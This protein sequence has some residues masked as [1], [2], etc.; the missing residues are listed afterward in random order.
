MAVT[1][2]I[3]TQEPA[4]TRVRDDFTIPRRYFMSN[5]KTVGS[6]ILSVF[7]FAALCAGIGISGCGG[8]GGNTPNVE[9]QTV[10]AAPSPV[11]PAAPDT[12]PPTA[13][14]GLTAAAISSSR[15]NLSWTAAT[16]NTAVMEYRVER[17]QGMGCTSFVEI[18]TALGAATT[19]SDTAGLVANTTYSYRVRAADAVPLLGPYSNIAQATTPTT[20]TQPPTAPTNL[21]ATAVSSSQ[22]NLGWAAATDNV[23]VTQYLIERCLGLCTNFSQIGTASGS[24]TTF[25]D[26]TA[27][28]ATSY[29]Y[30]VRA[31]DAAANFGPYSNVAS[32][33]TQASS[34]VITLSLV[35]SRTSGVGPLAVTFDATGTTDANV[36][37]L[38]FHEIQYSWD[39]G[40]SVCVASEGIVPGT[41]DY[42]SRAGVS[43]RNSATGPVASHIFECAGTFNVTLTAFDGTNS[44]VTTSFITVTSADLAYPNTA[45]TCYAQNTTGTFAGCP[46]GATQ[47]VQSNCITI[48]SAATANT[49]T[50]FRRGDV[51]TSCTPTFNAVGGHGL[52]GSFGS[53]AKPIL[54]GGRAILTIS[55]CTTPTMS[56]W[57]FM[58][59]DLDGVNGGVGSQGIVFNGGA[60]NITLLRLTV[61]NSADVG[62]L[63]IDPYIS[64]CLI[65]NPGN[66][67]WQNMAIVDSIVTNS[68]NYALLLD[69]KTFTLQ[70]NSVSIAGVTHGS[71]TIRCGLSQKSIWS[72]NDVSNAAAGIW[73]N[74]APDFVNATRA[75]PSGTYSEQNVYSDNKIYG[76][77][78]T[79]V[80]VFDFRPTNATRDERLRNNIFERNWVLTAVNGASAGMQINAQY[81]T[82]RNNLFDVT[83][84]GGGTAMGIGVTG[85]EPGPTGIKVYNNSVYSNST[86]GFSIA[87]INA[88]VLTAPPGITAYNNIG[89]API[90]L[91]AAIFNNGCGDGCLT[92]SNNT[93]N[94]VSQNPNFVSVA[95]NNWKPQAG[96]YA[97]G[98]GAPMLVPVWSDFFGVPISPPR[99]LG[100]VSH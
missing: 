77:S 34:N 96:S 25:N 47:S 86:G 68:G 95:T 57:R 71:H 31:T 42:G 72:N 24:A 65:A 52:V 10:L 38:P 7:F 55:D 16:D 98:A 29:N 67:I 58:D 40:D 36:T 50:L 53:G 74:R 83:L 63:A 80:V 4:G 2:F 20:D 84:G 73:T 54:R 12:T 9:L 61:R 69:V 93:M 92:Q 27:L 37:S 87:N 28:G 43:S 56:D 85:I 17:C 90:S 81:I 99:D 62:I 39:F 41:W 64:Q 14:S 88:G 91:G 97:I 59:L 26:V 46:S 45:T 76:R 11:P 100:A 60:D 3:Q 15:I 44:S 79:G 75:V 13:P 1:G 30:R 32:A 89:Y 51:W 23:A 5:C 6:G 33:T 22:I 78:A 8:G 35:P 94:A 49:R 66:H 19:F 18:A 82:V 70:G 21:T 48:A